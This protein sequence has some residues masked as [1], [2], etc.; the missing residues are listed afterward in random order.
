MVG[1]NTVFV[2]TIDAPEATFGSRII[3][4]RLM[5]IGSRKIRPLFIE[6]VNF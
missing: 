6:K 1:C 3:G 4:H 2:V 5:K